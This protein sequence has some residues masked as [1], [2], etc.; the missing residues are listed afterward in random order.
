MTKTCSSCCLVYLQ[1]SQ[2]FG[3][4]P[5]NKMGSTVTV[6]VLSCSA[7]RASHGSSTAMNDLG[8]FVGRFLDIY[9]VPSGEGARRSEAAAGCSEAAVQRPPAANSSSQAGAATSRPAGWR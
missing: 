4:I 2:Y 8:F 6:L 7:D 1:G 9:C 5:I 3:F